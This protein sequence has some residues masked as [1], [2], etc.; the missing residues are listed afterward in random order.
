MASHVALVPLMQS[1]RMKQGQWKGH[2]LPPVAMDLQ[3][4]E[5]NIAV[6]FIVQ[7]DFTC[8][9]QAIHNITFTNSCEF[10]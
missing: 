10:V 9:V 4:E 8:T 1:M 6:F 7:M 2:L 5:E 3:E